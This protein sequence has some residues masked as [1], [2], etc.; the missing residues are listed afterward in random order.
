MTPASSCAEIPFLSVLDSPAGLLGTKTEREKL[1][2]ERKLRRLIARDRPPPPAFP[3]SLFATASK[4]VTALGPPGGLDSGPMYRKWKDDPDDK[5]PRSVR[6][7]R[8]RLERAESGLRGFDLGERIGVRLAEKLR[9][10]RGPTEEAVPRMAI[11]REDS[12]STVKAATP[13]SFLLSLDDDYETQQPAVPSVPSPPLS[14]FSPESPFFDTPSSTATSLGPPRTPS[15]VPIPPKPKLGPIFDE[16]E[17]SPF[18][19]TP[20]EPPVPVPA[21]QDDYFAIRRRRGSRP[22]PTSLIAE[23]SNP[24]GSATSITHSPARLFPSPSPSQ[25]NRAVFAV[26]NAL[27]SALRGIESRRRAHLDL[28]VWV[29]VGAPRSADG[30]S[31][32]GGFAG[33]VLHLFGFSAFVLVHTLSLLVSTYATL[34]SVLVFLHWTFLNL[35]GRTDL[36]IVAAE[37]F[38]LC[39]NEWDKVAV[40]DGVALG[41]CSVLVGLAEIAAIQAMSGERWIGD[42]TRLSLLNGEEEQEEQEDEPAPPLLRRRSTKRRSNANGVG[43]EHPGL[44]RRRTTRTWTEDDGEGDSLLVTRGEGT[45]L[46]GTILNSAQSPT[47]AALSPSFTASSDQDDPPPFDLGDALPGFSFSPSSPRS[48]AVSSAPLSMMPSSPPLRPIPESN[49]L[50]ALLK[51]LKRHVRFATASYGLHAYIL[52]PPSPLFT[53]SGRNLP[54]RIFSH[55]GGIGSDNV[56]HVAIQNDY[57]GLPTPESA[58]E[59]WAP[60]LYV[61]RDDLHLEVVCVISVFPSHFSL[62]LPLTLSCF[63]LFQG[64]RSRLQTLGP[65]SKRVYKRF[66]YRRCILTAVPRPIEHTPGSSSQPGSSSYASFLLLLL[67]LFG[68]LTTFFAINKDPE[69]S[70]LFSKL[71]TVLNDHPG[72]SLVLTGHSLGAAIVRPRFITHTLSRYITEPSRA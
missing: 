7:D 2:R 42:Q 17:P 12:P 45:I 58:L 66:N 71:K 16:A 68:Q 15:L 4:L 41:V 22:R 46:E 40:E 38:A 43:I 28:I 13:M 50:I 67:L 63:S 32:V 36:S 10:E 61:L 53:P 25:P 60:Q 33:V 19:F 65:T 3:Q 5:V 57:L 23:D 47:L 29:L 56:L 55:L 18:P 30:L 8:R 27:G 34:R 31:G 64:G 20:H 48:S 6:Q 26:G 52:T 21:D 49:P 14:S 70:P 1:G 9:R 39:R 44:G 62:T 59:R 24:E 54:S 51:T 35:T 11:P 72:Y 69:H 37:Y